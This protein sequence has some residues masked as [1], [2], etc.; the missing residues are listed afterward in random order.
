MTRGNQTL[1]TRCPLPRPDSAAVALWAGA[2]ETVAELSVMR[3]QLRTALLGDGRP[4]GADDVGRDDVEQDDVERLLLVFEE[5]AS[6]GL[7]HG[8]PPVLVTVVATGTGWLLDVTDAAVDHAPAP[9]VGRDA[10]AGGLGLYLVARLC[11]AHGWL[12]EHD[13]K[14][15]WA[16]IDFPAADQPSGSAA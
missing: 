7:R 9:A 6:N 8:R 14:H 15:A 5:L 12:V 11:S 16:H 3:R 13:R 1:W 4:G 2:P 10:A